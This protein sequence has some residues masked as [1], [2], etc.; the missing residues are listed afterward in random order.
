MVRDVVVEFDWHPGFAASQKQK[1]IESLHKNAIACIGPGPFLEIS[2]KSPE[3]I[4][5]RLSAFHLLVEGF[6]DKPIPVENAFQGSKVFGPRQGPYHDLYSVPAL[7][8]KRDPRIRRRDAVV[9]FRTPKAVW[10]VIPRTAFYDWVY[11]RALADAPDLLVELR[12]YSGF[13]DIEFNPEKSINCQ[14][15][16]AALATGLDRQN[17]FVP[18][19]EDQASFINVCYPREPEQQSLL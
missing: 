11:L 14:A 17:L 15:R 13:T 19:M 8:A 6:A 18:S 16:S 1:S 3:L 9:E 10:P 7:D 5:T 2:S 4:G 12:R